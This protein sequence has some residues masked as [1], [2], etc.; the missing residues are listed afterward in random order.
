MKNFQRLRLFNGVEMI[1]V[2]TV[3]NTTTEI[4]LNGIN[5][6]AIT[7]DSCPVVAK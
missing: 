5:I 1:F 6:A 4:E 3:T 7:G 2:I